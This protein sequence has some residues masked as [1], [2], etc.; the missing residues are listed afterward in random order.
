MP[1]LV[2]IRKS[3]NLEALGLKGTGCLRLEDVNECT[4]GLHNCSIAANCVDQK[5]GYKCECLPE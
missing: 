4:L 3:D 1:G 5:I 2:D